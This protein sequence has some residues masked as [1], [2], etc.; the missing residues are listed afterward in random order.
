MLRIFGVKKTQKA[1]ED[2]SPVDT[3]I[4]LKCTLETLEKKEEHLCKQIESI[5]KKAVLCKKEGKTK[6]AL[7]QMKIVK[8]KEKQ[9]DFLFNS[10]LK[11]DEQICTLEQSINNK[12]IYEAI[13]KTKESLH[14][15]STNLDVDNIE[16]TM[17]DIVEH[18]NNIEDISN[19]LSQPINNFD[20]DE[21][22]NE[23]EELEETND[24]DC[25]PTETELVLPD[26]PSHEIII[27]EEEEILR[28]L[29]AEFYCV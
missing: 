5:K 13:H 20:D 8:Q 23:L 9:L 29:E 15:I 10:K 27:N 12:L 11:L 4:N 2:V 6:A 24:E 19:I 16:D 18:Q 28:Q 14:S 7:Q 3:I 21:L 22:L 26:A 25:S 17:D 1:K